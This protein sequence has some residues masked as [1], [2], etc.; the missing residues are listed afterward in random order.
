MQS[1]RSLS[2]A[3]MLGFF[4]ISS[5]YADT[6]TSSQRADMVKRGYKKSK[7]EKMCKEPPNGFASQGGLIWMPI[8]DSK[9][10]WTEANSYCSYRIING[11][12][13][14]RLP[15]NDELSAAYISGVMNDLGWTLNITWTSTPEGNGSHNAVLLFNGADA[16]VGDM[17]STYMTCV[18]SN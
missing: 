2:F 10:N 18:H 16:T 8:G 12:A 9:M 15:T 11:K 3:L 6:C 14:W 7:I 5:A 1:A 17:V 13:D 4:L